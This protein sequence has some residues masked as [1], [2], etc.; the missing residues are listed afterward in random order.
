MPVSLF[1][2]LIFPTVFDLCLR[3]ARHRLVGTGQFIGFPVR[4]L[5]PT[6]LA[7]PHEGPP[8][9]ILCSQCGL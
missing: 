9:K 3:E 4:P 5:P 8:W 7:A 1:L 6:A 2:C